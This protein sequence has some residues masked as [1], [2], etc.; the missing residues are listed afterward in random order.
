M[1]QD[2]S[3]VCY[4][5]M[6]SGFETGYIEFVDKRAVALA[7]AMDGTDFRGRVITVM[8]KRTNKSGFSSTDR[9]PRG[10]GARRRGS[11]FIERGR[12]YSTTHSRS[13]GFNKYCG[14]Y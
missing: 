11:R 5:V 4:D 8:P 2:L 12:F 13:R 7:M 10:F 9:R 3:M 1:D 14:P 6:E